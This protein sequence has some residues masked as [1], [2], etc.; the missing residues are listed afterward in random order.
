MLLSVFMAGPDRVRWELRALGPHGNGPFR[1]VIN[2][3]NG[4]IIEYFTDVTR[5][6]L[7]E[8]ELEA[9]LLAARST[10]FTESDVSWKAIDH[11]VQT[12]H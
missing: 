6:L 2:H 8:S 9:L 4:A 12:A 11:H 7:R 3:S 5:A 10:T 1:L